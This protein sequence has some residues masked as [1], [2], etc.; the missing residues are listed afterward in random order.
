[1]LQQPL[2]Q[3]YSFSQKDGSLQYCIDLQR[4]NA[5]TI[6]DTYSI[7]QIDE[8]LDCLGEAIIFTSLDLKSGYWQ[9][10]IDE[11]F[12]LLTTF[13]LCP[14]GFYKCERMPFGLTNAP[15]TFQCLM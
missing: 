10:E 6:K 5:Y 15:A 11:K 2:G 3:H 7:P 13:T 4:L 14:F 8:T 9:V 1:M 12:K